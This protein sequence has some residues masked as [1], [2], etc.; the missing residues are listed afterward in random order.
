MLKPSPLLKSRII[1]PVTLLLSSLTVALLVGEWLLRMGL[2]VLPPAFLIY[3][4]PVQ[5]E[6]VPTVWERIRE[7]NPWARGRKDDPVLGWTFEP[8][9]LYEGRN[10]DGEVYSL[11]T[12]A[13]G[14]FTPD[15]PDA[16]RRQLVT[17]GDSFMSTFYVQ[18]PLPWVLKRVTGLPVFNLAAG[19]WGVEQYRLAFERHAQGRNSPLVVVFTFNN[20]ITDVDNW[21]RWK[22]SGT[23]L[24][25]MTWIWKNNPDSEINTGNTWLDA[26]SLLWNYLKFSYQQ[27]NQQLKK[28]PS[29]K[30]MPAENPAE[31][32][33]EHFF[34]GKEDGGFD[35][36]FN[37]GYQFLHMEPEEFEEGG[38]YWPYMAAYFDALL[39]LKKS[40][41]EAGGKMALVWIP[42]KER[43]YIPLLPKDRYRN[44]VTTQSGRLDGLERVLRKFAEKQKISFLD[45]T[46]D[47]TRHASLGEKLYFTMD[48]HLN[49]LG[50]RVAGEVAGA[51]IH[52]L[53]KGK[54]E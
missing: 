2:P 52:G 8:D 23:R 40:I 11:R 37:G 35:L 48:G 13:A 46:D 1:G 34:S 42:A 30:D 32:K 22:A 38:R 20:D 53:M 7:Y 19:G 39:K 43:V 41:E 27:L 28:N 44:Y 18:E 26:H 10:E 12:S 9:R 45:L 5:K 31:L 29:P 4:H 14:F 33:A 50:N 36:V 54:G 24:D 16:A 47:L 49:S 6:A 3:L 17:L 15:E 21:R 51:F 25:F